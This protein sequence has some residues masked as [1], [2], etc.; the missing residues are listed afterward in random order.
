MF[1]NGVFNM[2]KKRLVPIWV[3]PKT[4]SRFKK[5][6]S[7]FDSIVEMDIRHDDAMKKLL[8][9]GERHRIYLER[10]RARGAK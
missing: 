2:A 4:K 9:L 8:E 6:Y 5:L 3:N 1:I 10:K 7:F